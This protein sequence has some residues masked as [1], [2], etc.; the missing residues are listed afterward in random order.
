MRLFF[1]LLLAIASTGNFLFAQETSATLSGSVTDAKGA[2][3]QGA[4][5][6]VTYL[7][8]NFKTATLTN[9]KGLYVLPNLKSG[10]PYT[11]VISFVGFEDQKFENV[12]L[13][14]GNNPDVNVA[15]KAGEK[16]LQE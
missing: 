4:T 5:I 1:T 10:G 8:T 15:L 11:V 12:N 14:L 7:P 9:N 6:S 2:P 13:G 3:V 16:S